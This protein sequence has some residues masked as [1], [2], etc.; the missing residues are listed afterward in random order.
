MPSTRP[1]D[2]A[3]DLDFTT[4]VVLHA[5]DL[6]VQVQDPAVRILEQAERLADT[7]S[8]QLTLGSRDPRIWHLLAGLYLG[9]RRS[10]DYDELSKRHIAMF[11]TP[12]QLELPAAV[13]TLPDKINQD[14]LPAAGAVKSACASP[15][16][17]V[18]DFSNVRRASTGGIAELG[19]L[20]L[21]LADTPQAPE[22]R[23]VEDFLKSVQTVAETERGSQAMWDLLFAYPRFCHDPKSFEEIALKY[24]AHTGNVPPNW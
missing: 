9:S 20:L 21:E 1:T 11:G 6:R 16:G 12:L 10:A 24:R 2:S 22:L 19:R 5:Q 3:P 17:A 8:L 7:M 13:F 18:I 23:G 14:S 4:T 15:G